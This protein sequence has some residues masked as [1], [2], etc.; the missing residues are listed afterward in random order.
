MLGIQEAYKPQLDEVINNTWIAAQD[1]T[2]KNPLRYSWCGQG[3]GGKEKGEYSAILYN[4][5]RLQLVQSNTFWLTDKSITTPSKGWDAD[6]VR[7]CTWA[8][9][10]DLANGGR[11]FIFMNTHWDH[12]GVKAQQGAA[13]LMMQ[14]AAKISSAY[15]HKD[16][17]PG[18]NDHLK[19]MQ[20]SL[21]VVI[22]GDFNVNQLH[23]SYKVL[24]ESNMVYDAYDLTPLDCVV[25]PCSTYNGWS[26]D[27]KDTR[28][29]SDNTL[30]R[31]D[32]IFI[33]KDWAVKRWQVWPN[34]V[35]GPNNTK[36]FP[37]DHYPLF[38]QLEWLPRRDHTP[39]APVD[40]S[41]RAIIAPASV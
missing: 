39:F 27:P 16:R 17:V 12:K 35:P 8:L 40:H 2:T 14:Q 10:R 36:I 20:E 29:A 18:P 19:Q 23:P 38:V 32:H 26:A 21:P 34:T 9:F 15:A 1:A 30:E 3:N 6:C 41:A 28:L 37:S 33:T 4:P 7:I 24:A 25:Q 5:Q 22:T 13:L 11:E 31:I